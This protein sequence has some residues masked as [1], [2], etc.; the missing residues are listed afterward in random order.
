MYEDERETL[1]EVAS[2]QIQCELTAAMS[3][4]LFEL[5]NDGIPPEDAVLVVQKLFDLGR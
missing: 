4:V 2:R 1:R 5:I 3:G